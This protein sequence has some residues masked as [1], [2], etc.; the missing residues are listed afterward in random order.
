MTGATAVKRGS[1]DLAVLGGRPAF[2]E[3]LY[4]G[5]P[6]LG[7]R[8]R[9][10]ER[11]HD[12][13]DTAWLTNNGPYVRE[14]E[15]R[16]AATVGA[17]HCIAMCN[18]TI[19]LEIAIRALGLTDEVIVPAMTFVATAHAL[20]WQQ[21][22]PVFADVDPD[23]YNLDPTAV[24]RMITPGTT[25]IIGVHLWGR[26]CDTEGLAEL[27]ARRGLKLLYDASHA[28]GCS[29]RGRMI[30][31]FGAAEIF[32][33]HATKFVNALEGGAI[34]TNDDELAARVQLMRN[35]GFAG[36]DNVIDIGT[37]GKMNEVAA[38]AGLTALEGM[39]GFVR[40]NRENYHAYQKEL[41]PLPGI[42]MLAFD[43]TE[44]A[45][46]QYI[47]IEIEQGTAGLGRDDLMRVLHAENVVARRYFYPGC[48][49][50]EP[51][52]STLPQAGR[53]LPVTERLVERVLCLPT[54]SSIGAAEIG[55]V[56]AIVR[57]ALAHTA[58][59]RRRLR[60]LDEA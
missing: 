44:H 56:C 24:E 54:G 53:F 1:G 7:V 28:F 42:R 41:A 8:A 23:T 25:G 10:L 34:V 39:E 52:R 2:G 22:T 26:A 50:M 16:V 37:N 29:R 46:Y 35:F 36:Y 3:P 11:V 21:I 32:S 13:L 40:A 19:A 59:V 18:G 20:Q 33:F 58:E 15:R 31:T 38:A 49:R 12:I 6:N 55:T 43:E 51:Y 30:G 60:E 47:V 45:N 5:R 48:H 17:R 4:V 57:L 14:F 27:A 9:F